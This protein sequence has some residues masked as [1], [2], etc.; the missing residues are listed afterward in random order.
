MQ[1]DRRAFLAA[2]TGAGAL[3]L[4]KGLASQPA[5]RPRAAPP[6]TSW[7]PWLEIDTAN[8]LWNLRQIQARVGGKKVMAV[9][10]ANAYGHGLVD[11][12][13][14]LAAAGVEHFL[15]GKLDEARQLR[16]AG[17]RGEILN[18]GPFSEAE[19]EEIVR[20]GI[21]QNVYD[22]RAQWLD[23]AA[24][25]AGR[26]ARVHMKVD[27][28]LGRV[29]VP[30]DQALDFIERLARLRGLRMAGVF[31]TFTEDAEF[32]RV[33]LARF[34]DICD[35]AAQRGIA[36]G[37]RHAASSAAILDFP[38]SYEQLDMVRPGIMLYGLYPSSRAAQQRKLALRPVLS[39]K[40][41][42]AQV[43]TLAPGESVSYHR[44]FLAR[45]PERIA[46]LAV[47]YSDGLPREL[48]EKGN[49]L[50]A[51]RRCPLVAISAN[52]TIARLGD[53]P[54]AAGDEAVLLGA[55]GGE[56]ITAG[57]MA[58]WAGG[59]VY[60]V[61]IEMSALLPRRYLPA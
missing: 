8:L 36:L 6:A 61:V 3:L 51:G 58:Q 5:E 28:G 14:A 43:K 40:V 59:S 45:Q 35:R 33:Q 1:L 29:G 20:L 52:A 26:R 31:T 23:R 46:T 37:L 9:V 42:V 32:D 55:Q 15:V 17:I 47:G 11:T 16:Q 54:A 56:E 7:D 53:A 12:T 48:V 34:R 27:T 30:H 49:A 19:A 22:D 10:K 44:A 21:A 4:P 50:V 57:E 25:R 2:A 39:L 13:R 24:Q 60:A 38:E 18:F 41:R